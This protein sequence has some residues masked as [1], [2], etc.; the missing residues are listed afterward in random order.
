MLQFTASNLMQLSQIERGAFINRTL[1]ALAVRVDGAISSNT[2]RLTLMSATEIKAA[3]LAGSNVGYA[4][5]STLSD[6]I[7]T[8]PVTITVHDDVFTSTSARAEIGFDDEGGIVVSGAARYYKGAHA[9]GI[10]TVDVTYFSSFAGL[11]DLVPSI[12]DQDGRATRGVLWGSKTNQANADVLANLTAPATSTTAATTRI[13]VLLLS[14]TRDGVYTLRFHLKP[15]VLGWAGRFRQ[16]RHSLMPLTF[17]LKNEFV[18]FGP[19]GSQ[20]Y[21]IHHPFGTIPSKSTIE[22]TIEYWSH[23]PVRFAASLFCDSTSDR[24]SERDALQSRFVLSN[25]D[26]SNLAEPV[27]D[28][29]RGIMILRVRLGASMLTSEF[30]RYKLRLSMGTH[31]DGSW[32]ETIDRSPLHDQARLTLS[33]LPGAARADVAVD[34]AAPLV[35]GVA[36]TERLPGSIDPQPESKNTPSALWLALGSAL[37]LALVLAGAAYVRRQRVLA[38]TQHSAAIAPTAHAATRTAFA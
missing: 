31:L 21:V 3:F 33:R 32:A 34:A 20:D 2:V 7:N 27:A 28:G 9:R 24:C 16:P 8:A 37:A 11:L 23:I 13:R 12:L 4:L 15:A 5:A 36:A 30:R 35:T 26:R 25:G 38:E 18:S 22:V 14:Q 29:D 19:A 1:A 10:V 6:S 17:E